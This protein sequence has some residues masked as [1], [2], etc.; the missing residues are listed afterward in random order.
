VFDVRF[1]LLGLKA[2]SPQLPNHLMIIGV[3]R[4]CRRRGAAAFPS[5]LRGRGRV[6]NV[7]HPAGGH[8]AFLIDH[9]FAK[10]VGGK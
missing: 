2:E 9:Y 10:P 1:L 4:G 6:A 8:S 5:L 3:P 7:G